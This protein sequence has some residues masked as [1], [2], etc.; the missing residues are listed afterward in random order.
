MSAVTS[1]FPVLE[2]IPGGEFAVFSALFAV[3]AA[4]VGGGDVCGGGCMVVV[5]HYLAQA[6]T[7]R[8]DAQFALEAQEGGEDI[9][10]LL[11]LG[12]SGSGGLGGGIL[13]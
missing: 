9:V 13:L 6:Q 3:A 2:L 11:A 8:F 5:L 4:C 10:V 1:L 7:E 12:G